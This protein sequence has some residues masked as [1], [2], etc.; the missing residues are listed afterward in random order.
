MSDHY[1]TYLEMRAG[2]QRRWRFI[3]P[4]QAMAVMVL[5]D[6]LDAILGG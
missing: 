4:A 6:L 2:S 5:M 1:V 3:R